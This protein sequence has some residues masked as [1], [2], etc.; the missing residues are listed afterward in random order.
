MRPPTVAFIKSHGRSLQLLAAHRRFCVS[1]IITSGTPLSRQACRPFSPLPLSSSGAGFR[2]SDV[3][4]SLEVRR[5]LLSFEG[6][7]QQLL[8]SAR[9]GN[10]DGAVSALKRGASVT[11][12]DKA[13]AYFS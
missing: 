1:A 3:A 9:D 5:L 4:G 8:D 10:L 6:V 11:C 13:R 7:N 2:P 12:L